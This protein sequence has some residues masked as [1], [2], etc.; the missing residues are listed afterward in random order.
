MATIAASRPRRARRILVWG[1]AVLLALGGIA[2]GLAALAWSA[3]AHTTAGTVAFSRPLAIPPLAHSTVDADGRRVFD[4]R[5]QKGRADFGLGRPT[6]TWGVN[7]DYLGPTLRAERGEQVAVRVTNGVGE[8]TTLHWHG[9]HLPPVMD[10]GPHQ[11]IE[12]GGVWYPSWQIEQPAATL[13]YHPHLHGDTAEHVYRGLAGMF[14]IDDPDAEPGLPRDYGVDDLPVIVQ[15]KSFTSDGQLNE[16]DPLFSPTG[17]QGD[18]VV[19][20]GTISPYAEV[21]TE[22]V[23][24]RL[25]NASNA[26][27]Y[28]F[29]LIEPGG[30]GRDLVLVGSDGGLLP[31]PLATDRVQLSP[32]ER[33]EI[34]VAMEPGEDVVLRSFP[35]ELG[36][37]FW[38][39][40]F[41]GGDDTLDVLELRAADTLDSSAAMPD[42]LAAAPDLREDDAVTTRSF[43]LSGTAINGQDMNL[44]RVD[45]VVRLGDTEL[46]KVTNADG[47][48]HNFHVHGV[49]FHILDVNGTAPPLDLRG[50]KD[51]I[52]LAPSSVVR[53]VMRFTDYADPGSPYMFHCHLLRHE[54]RGMMGQFVVVQ[55]DD[56]VEPRGRLGADASHGS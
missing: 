43:R 11:M 47:T 16:D 21:T 27:V 30:K 32:G 55:A 14:L 42:H 41:A 19:V 35:P 18:T 44:N 15:D 53:L 9:M 24:L 1:L 54:D 25:L 39:E 2:A 45:E 29:G 4:L 37:N 36:A 34:V 56:D 20:N 51:T 33:A 10:G 28:N 17:F 5:L 40:R 22:A 3:A 38:T 8:A 52:Y 7:G 31:R 48:P 23:R 49:Q 12:P 46:W 26:R 6:D 13:W 50:W